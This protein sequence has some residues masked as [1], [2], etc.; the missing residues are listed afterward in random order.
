MI[1][2]RTACVRTNH[3]NYVELYYTELSRK[4][5]DELVAHL[6]DL[7]S[8]ANANAPEPLYLFIN[9]S[10]IKDSPPMTYLMRQM[11]SRRQDLLLKTTVYGALTFNDTMIGS[12]TKSMVSL[13]RLGSVVMQGFSVTEVE[14]ARHWLEMKIAEN[15]TEQSMD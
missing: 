9:S 7:V 11:Q 1:D 12:F 10:G 6:I 8:E 5:M 13:L 2:N 15:A 14:E 3:E 4:A